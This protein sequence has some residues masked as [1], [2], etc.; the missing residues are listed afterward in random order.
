M[1]P[2][3]L[4][5][6]K[7]QAVDNLVD[8]L[9]VG[10]KCQSNQVEVGSLYG[11]NGPSVGDIVRRCEHLLAI[12]RGFHVAADGSVQGPGECRPI[13]RVDQDRLADERVIARAGRILVW[14]PDAVGICRG[15]AGRDENAC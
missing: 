4:S 8:D 5:F 11:P 9:P 13:G 2:C 12:D 15:Y 3:L 10:A 14:L 7:L 6:V 1:Q